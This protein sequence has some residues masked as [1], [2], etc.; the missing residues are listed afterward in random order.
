MGIGARPVG[1]YVI[2]GSQVKWKPAFDLS[3]VIFRGQI[4]VLTALIVA[5]WVLRSRG[6][7]H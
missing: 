2:Q 4:I 5:G 3:R 6:R 7:A 1:A